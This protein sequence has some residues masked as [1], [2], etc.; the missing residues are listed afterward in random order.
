MK[1]TKHL[2]VALVSSLFLS[3][4]YAGQGGEG[5]NTGCN[6]VGN[7]NS[8]CG[9]NTGGGNGGNGGNGGS[10][11]TGGTGGTGIGVG[12]GLGIGVGT[13]QASSSVKSEI[14][15]KN[16]NNVFTVAEGGK[17]S[18]SSYSGVVGS[19]NSNVKVTVEGDKVPEKQEIHYSGTYTVKNVPNVGAAALTSS[20]DTCMGSSSGGAAGPGFG[21]SIGTT[22]TDNNCK[23][24]KN[25]RELW[26]MGMKAAALALM[27]NDSDNRA[28]LEVTG[29]VCPG[30]KSKE[31]TAEATPVSSN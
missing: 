9:G 22:W 30:S 4:A 26:N 24:L 10:G 29:Y 13:A 15:V 2:V 6:G 20:N 5:N 31:Q 23:M 12:V 3:I 17:A 8:P 21:L 28:A 14:D 25:S 11:G 19:G 1:Q 18:S 27:C 16:S 7:P